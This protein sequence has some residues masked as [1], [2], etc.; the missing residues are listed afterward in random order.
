MDLPPRYQRHPRL[1][2][3]G[4]EYSE[5]DIDDFE[6][7]LGEIFGRGIHR[8][9]VMEFG[10]LP[11][12]MAEGLT[13]R[14]LMEHRDDHGRVCFL[15]GLRGGYLRLEGRGFMKGTK[16]LNAKDLVFKDRM[17]MN[18]VALGVK[19]EHMQVQVIGHVLNVAASAMTPDGPKA[20]SGSVDI[21]KEIFYDAKRV[22]W[23][24]TD[25]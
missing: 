12:Q 15:A 6:E 16:L 5:G 24:L 4:L 17:V 9:Q 13:A 7:R 3:K 25:G 22:T 10:G 2:F 19:K 14:M 23:D 11:R 8:V 20:L 18:I 1:R 21:E